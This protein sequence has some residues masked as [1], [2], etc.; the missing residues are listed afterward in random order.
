MI[1]MSAK[2]RKTLKS[3]LQKDFSK[4][5]AEEILDVIDK[6]GK[7]AT[8][9]EKVEKAV[10]QYIRHHIEKDVTAII[11][12]KMIDIGPVNLSPYGSKPK[13]KK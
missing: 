4:A 7:K 11:T 2:S 9:I 3:A 8:N 6:L 1:A 10:I 12:E 5:V 13:S